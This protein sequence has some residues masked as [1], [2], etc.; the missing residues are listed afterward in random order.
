[1]TAIRVYQVT[2]SSWMPP[3]CRFEPSCSRY[4]HEAL[5]LHGVLRGVLLTLRRVVRCRPGVPGG[6]D[7]VPIPDDPVPSAPTVPTD[8]HDA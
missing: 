5:R 6:Y 2:V 8:A 3:M 1:M 4:G 7:P